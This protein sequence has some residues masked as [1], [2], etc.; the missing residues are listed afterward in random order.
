MRRRSG[1][2]KRS[3]ASSTCKNLSNSC[4]Q[5]KKWHSSLHRRRPLTKKWCRCKWQSMRSKSKPR[6]SVTTSTS[7]YR[8]V[9]TVCLEW[10][11]SN[12]RLRKC[13]R[14]SCRRWDIRRNRWSK[15][16]GT[17][18]QLASGANYSIKSIRRSLRTRIPWSNKILLAVAL[19]PLHH[20]LLW[21]KDLIGKKL[22]RSCS[23][24]WVQ[25]RKSWSWKSILMPSRSSS[26]CRIQIRR[27]ARRKHL[28]KL[29]RRALVQLHTSNLLKSA[30]L[31]GLLRSSGSNLRKKSD[32]S[33]WLHRRRHSVE[34]DRMSQL[35]MFETRIN[36][37]AGQTKV[38]P[39]L[40]DNC[41]VIF[42]STKICHW[43]QVK[44]TNVTW[45]T[46]SVNCS[47][48]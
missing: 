16:N 43:I 37:E 46:A 7:K 21:M 9:K 17:M 4:T 1:R 34:A 31:M 22:S 3:F 19:L 30:N 18:R 32:G 44:R 42:S 45:A 28:I 11:C 36:L 2:S 6:T 20:R 35:M 13:V 41:S 12:V 29:F 26:W 5:S 27:A 40:L 8:D 10:T 38:P 48:C 23:E 24:T 39:S 15:W 25:C 14:K 47:E 33:S